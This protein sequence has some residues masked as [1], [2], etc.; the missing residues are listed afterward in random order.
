MEHVQGTF[1]LHRNCIEHPI[2]SIDGTQEVSVV[3]VL[4]L[5][6]L[7]VGQ[8]RHNTLVYPMRN[9]CSTWEVDEVSLVQ[10]I[11]FLFIQ[12]V[13]CLASRNIRCF[14]QSVDSTESCSVF[15]VIIELRAIMIC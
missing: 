3:V 7:H 13:L 12:E 11:N 15:R 9:D 4:L 10:R 2:V 8:I 14:C 6:Q 1:A 5:E